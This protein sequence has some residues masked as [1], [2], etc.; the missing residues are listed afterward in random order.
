RKTPGPRRRRAVGRRTAGD[1]P[2]FGPARPGRGRHR[3][4]ADR[5]PWPA[6]APAGAGAGRDGASART[7][8][9]PRLPADGGAGAGQPLAGRRPGAR[10]GAHRSRFGRPLLRPAP[11]RTGD[12]G[13]RRAVPRHP[14]PRAGVRGTVPRHHRRRRGAPARSGAARAGAQRRGGDRR[15]QPPQ[16][17]PRAQ[18]RGPRRDRP[19]QAVAGAGGRAPAGP[20]RDRRWR[21][22][23]A[24]GAGVGL[25]RWLVVGGWGVVGKRNCKDPLV[26]RR[27]V[28]LVPE[29]YTVVRR[30]PR[31]ENFAPGDQLRRAVVPVA[32]N[33][34]EGQSRRHPGEFLQY[35][36]VA[37]GSLAELH[38]Q[39]VVAERLDYIPGISSSA[40]NTSSPASPAPCPVWPRRSRAPQPHQPPTISAPTPPEMPNS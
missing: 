16:R 26:W 38:T 20:F 7:R 18:R 32:A 33:I 23:V 9:G 14:P 25:N 5:T 17:K 29:V 37:K 15:P 27:A 40:S 24:G 28:D 1:L 12:R 10:R 19:A 21:A 8:T 34:A 36:S 3:P 13:V 11:A 35:L 2:G 31:E 39:L 22:G 4:P 6:A 30:L